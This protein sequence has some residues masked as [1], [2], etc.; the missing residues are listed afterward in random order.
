MKIRNLLLSFNLYT[1]PLSIRLPVLSRRTK[2][3]G[4]NN[5]KNMESRGNSQSEEYS[6]VWNSQLF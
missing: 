1:Y 4:T 6:T 5:I 3:Q 2:R